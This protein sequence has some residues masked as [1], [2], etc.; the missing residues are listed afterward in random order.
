MRLDQA[1]GELVRHCLNQQCTDYVISHQIKKAF[2][3]ARKMRVSN[4]SKDLM[5]DLVSTRHSRTS[6][7]ARKPKALE[8]PVKYGMPARF[9]KYTAENLK[10]KGYCTDIRGAWKFIERRGTVQKSED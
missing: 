5:Y 9:P 10:L 7:R 6:G 1:A 4:D 8:T 3:Q 2:T